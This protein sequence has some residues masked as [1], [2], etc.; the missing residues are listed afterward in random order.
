MSS[1]AV[2]TIFD[3]AQ[4]SSI[5]HTK[6]VDKLLELLSRTPEEEFR[7]T[8]VSC[9][10]IAL[11]HVDK[12]P[13]I[14]VLEFV[15]QF[16]SVVETR[17]NDTV[18]ASMMPVRNGSDKEN[19]D[20]ENS[21]ENEEEEEEDPMNPFV[22]NFFREL[23]QL[24]GCGNQNVR[25]RVCFCI[26]KILQFLGPEATIDGDI[27]EEIY[28]AMV[29]RLKDKSPSVR[30][31]AVTA[32][33]RLQD[34]SDPECPVVKAFLFHMCMDP[35]AD[36][37]TVV[38]MCLGRSKYS[39]PYI[40]NRIHD[41]KDTVRK[42]AYVSL[43]KVSIRSH[44]IKDRELILSQ[45]L[46]ERSDSVRDTVEKVLLP[47]WFEN[48][49]ENFL[50]FLHALDVENSV[51]CESAL[52]VLFRL[53]TKDKLISALHLDSQKLV[54]IDKLT[55]EMAFYWHCL[56]EFLQT[57][58][59]G[60]WELVLPELSLFC[61]YINRNLEKLKEV[62]SS[63][64]LETWHH[65]QNDFVIQHLLQLT[66]VFD[67]ADEAGREK[68]KQLLLTMLLNGNVRLKVVST[69]MDVLVK[70]VPDVNTRLML[71]AETISEI[72]DPLVEENDVPDEQRRE[73]DF[74][75]A[76]LRVNKNILEEDLEIAVKEKRYLEAEEIKNNI[77][78]LTE[79]LEA[80][81]IIPKSN[82]GSPLNRGDDPGILSKCLT[83]VYEM[84]QSPSVKTLS[85]ELRSLL[86][87]FVKNSLKI[88]H[89]IVQVIAL[90][91][92]AVFS[93]LDEE[94]AKDVIVILCLYLGSSCEEISL[95]AAKGI[96]D[97]L[98]MYGL[99]TF[100]ISED[101]DSLD[102]TDQ[103][104]KQKKTLMRKSTFL[105]DCNDD[106]DESM[107]FVDTIDNNANGDEKDKEDDKKNYQLLTLLTKHLDSS[108]GQ[109]LQCIVQGLCKLL[110][111]MRISS[112][113]L[114]SRL[115][116]LW[117]NPV[118]E[119]E[120][121]LRQMLGLFF[122]M[123]ATSCPLSQETLEQCFLPTINTLLNAP[124][125]SPLYQVNIENVA[126][127]LLDLTKNGVNQLSAEVH[128][129]NNLALK[130]CNELLLDN[131]EQIKSELI[132]ILCHMDLS[133]DEDLQRD[134]KKRAERIS[135]NCP[136]RASTRAIQKFMNILNCGN[137]TSELV[138][139]VE[140]RSGNETLE[141]TS[142]V[143][144]SRRNTTKPRKVSKRNS[145]SSDSDAG[146]IVINETLTAIHRSREVVPE[147]SESDG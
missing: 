76:Q 81:S 113:K 27:C 73:M 55:V 33:E 114:V 45:G 42:Q 9:V 83:I 117:F 5:H 138:P 26:K 116:L 66:K 29:E 96:F 119:D 101:D 124:C 112:P 54:P 62:N 53:Q 12:V 4:V 145:G 47:N 49:H 146:K 8:F 58:E 115:I 77:S 142:V 20:L 74:K 31:Q 63:G 60:L 99:T 22:F 28:S 56:A 126:K 140:T 104:R 52:K 108:E 85:P 128:I 17:K 75:L 14:R 19:M 98:L 64:Q 35:S 71:A 59:D 89:A 110:L 133:L 10:K 7:T 129:H 44:S 21:V 2:Q 137:R 37:R 25:T 130:L 69:I 103:K 16:C 139:N 3:K 79:E 92:L 102:L 123:Y 94:I 122:K 50:D 24:N 72:H 107:Y 87:N 131:Y 105:D 135:K 46:K 40:R 68:L 1:M 95:V 30:T 111:A 43:S 118:Y 97:L 11:T 134:L 88:E 13:A 18:L 61:E 144:A 127:F 86:E 121:H 125:S 136:D 109:L 90:Q 84:M 93:L 51:I 91:C 48:C 15:A 78:K 41:V 106:N 6:L 143:N 38:L 141:T 67:L 70:V 57:E 100:C 36:V 65:T 23:L 120:L 39:L 34:P 82:G 147:S 80:V 32:L 132:N